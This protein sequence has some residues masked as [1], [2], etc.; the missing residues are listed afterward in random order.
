MAFIPRN[1]DRQD[2]PASH[3]PFIAKLYKENPN[4]ASQCPISR[5]IP[6]MNRTL[7]IGCEAGPD[8]M[9]LQDALNALPAYG[10]QGLHA[11]LIVDGIFGPRTRLRV[12]EFQKAS[13]LAADGKVSIHVWEQ[14]KRLLSQIPGLFTTRPLGGGPGGAGGKEGGKDYGGKGGYGK[15][16]DSKGSGGKIGH[17][18]GELGAKPLGHTYGKSGPTAKGKP[19]YGDPFGGKSGGGDYG[20]GK[21]PKSGYGSTGGSGKAAEGGN[22]GKTPAYVKSVQGGFGWVSALKGIDRQRLYSSS[23][24]SSSS[25]KGSGKDSGGDTGGGSK[26]KG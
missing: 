26:G 19:T 3:S 20:G 4:T 24:S 23:S 18:A 9:D 10:G 11:L 15:E 2:N 14:I 6:A 13:G 8:V 16:A 5:G 25:G 17:F 21:D 12:I 1:L 7:Q 22:P